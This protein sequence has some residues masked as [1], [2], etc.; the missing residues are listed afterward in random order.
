MLQAPP[1]Y[2][3]GDR[4]VAV[5]KGVGRATQ[6]SSMPTAPSTMLRMVPLPVP[7]RIYAASVVSIQP[8]PSTRSPA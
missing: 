8:P 5:V 6:P 1:R 7:E 2:G 4:R 3:K